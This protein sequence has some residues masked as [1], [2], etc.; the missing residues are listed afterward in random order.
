MGEND[1]GHSFKN[2]IEIYE[3]KSIQL[4]P[5]DIKVPRLKPTKH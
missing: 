4:N 2:R 3:N 5:E 1:I